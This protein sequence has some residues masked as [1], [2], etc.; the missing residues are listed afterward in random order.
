MT[1]S[2]KSRERHGKILQAIYEVSGG[3]TKLCQ[4]ED[5]VVSAWKGWPEEFGLRGYVDEYPDSS[6]LHKPLYGP[7]KREGFVRSGNKSFGLTERGVSEVQ[8][9]NGKGAD[10]AGEAARGRLSRD[11]KR[12]IVRLSESPVLAVALEGDDLLDTDMYEFYGVTVRTS[13]ADF[14]GRISTVDAAIDAALASS[15]PSVG[16]QEVSV[17]TATRDRLRTELEELISSSIAPNKKG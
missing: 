14:Q 10:D 4:Y 13:P 11:Q 2:A 7:L 17:I 8:S 3:T 1:A 6:D 15:D 5:I 16:H 9:L 12:E